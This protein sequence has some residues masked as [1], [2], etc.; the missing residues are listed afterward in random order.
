VTD[1]DAEDGVVVLRELVPEV[2]H[3]A[4]YRRVRSQNRRDAVV[5]TICETPRFR[6]SAVTK[7]G[8]GVEETKQV[9]DVSLQLRKDICGKRGNGYERGHSIKGPINLLVV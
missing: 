3:A 4:H 5:E 2:P 8:S 6:P 1:R 7:R 9:T